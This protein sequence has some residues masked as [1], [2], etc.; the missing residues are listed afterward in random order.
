LTHPVVVAITTPK[1]ENVEQEEKKESYEERRRRMRR[2]DTR[3][4]RG[5][6]RMGLE[7]PKGISQR[8]SI[9]G[10]S[11]LRKNEETPA[12]APTEASAVVNV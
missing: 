4:I 11:G 2:M 5:E 3:F 6:R 12:V 1:E 10:N 7:G 9:F 8:N